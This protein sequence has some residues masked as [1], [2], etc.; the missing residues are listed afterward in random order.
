MLWVIKLGGSFWAAEGLL[1]W[2]EVL[3]K[4][5]VIVVP[6]GGVFADAVRQAQKR[7]GFDDQLAHRL[8]ISAMHQYGLMLQGL[9]PELQTA[10]QPSLLKE[11]IENGQSILWLP[12][13]ESLAD[14]RINA[15]WEVT[16]DSLAAWLA[17]NLGAEHLLLVKSVNPPP[18]E[19]KISDLIDR[20]VVDS[21]FLEMSD[22]FSGNIWL[23]GP[24]PYHPFTAAM[25]HP[26]R[27]FTRA[28]SL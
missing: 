6:G 13:A 7:W 15:S 10:T 12:D 27:F 26:R 20:G 16:S 17:E 24:Q 23:T 21:A 9:W 3:A 18:G 25:A 19:A 11:A 4:S 28:L 22:D 2:L 1:A 14:P 8:A 5:A